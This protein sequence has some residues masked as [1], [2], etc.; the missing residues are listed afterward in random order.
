LA[1]STNYETETKATFEA[2]KPE[3]YQIVK[4]TIY[5][6][7]PNKGIVGPQVGKSALA[8]RFVRNEFTNIDDPT[9][10]IHSNKYSYQ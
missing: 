7:L 5:I 4:Y 8:V 6:F 9:V 3:V 1:S 10:G 2:I